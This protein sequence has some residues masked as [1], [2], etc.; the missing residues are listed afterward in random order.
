M[1]NGVHALDTLDQLFGAAQ[2]LRCED[3]SLR[4]G[5]ESNV[6]LELHYPQFN[7]HGT[8][9]LSQD[10]SLNNGLWIR[11]ARGEVWLG[12]DDIAAYRRRVPG[13]EW[14]KTR[15]TA[16]SPVT[17][18]STNPKCVTPDSYYDCIWLQWVGVMRAIQWGEAPAVDGVKATRV[19]RAIE[20]AYQR[21]E[22]LDLP[23]LSVPE[24]AALRANH[25][26]APV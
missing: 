16:A 26:R 18:N 19:I 9:Q 10:Q 5:V 25:W 6:R 8:L 21:V 24:C 13:G 4:D 12:L 7:A 15:A 11:G 20:S 2:V 17:L 23:W 14:R 1:D 3:D 22:P